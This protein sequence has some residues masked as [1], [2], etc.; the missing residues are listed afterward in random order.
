MG[1]INPQIAALL[2]AMQQQSAPPPQRL[3]DDPTA[4]SRGQTSLHPSGGRG[5]MFNDLVRSSAP[6]ESRAAESESPDHIRTDP[7]QSYEGASAQLD[8]N[9]PEFQ[10]LEG[11]RGVA[12][13]NLNAANP[14][15]NGFQGLTPGQLTQIPVGQEQR[16]MAGPPQETGA[17]S[18]SRLDNYEKMLSQTDPAK[19]A[20]LALK[21]QEMQMKQAQAEHKADLDRFNANTK[22][23]PIGGA[24]SA[25][26]DAAKQQTSGDNQ[27]AKASLSG[28]GSPQPT[29]PPDLLPGSPGF[30]GNE[31]Q[32]LPTTPP[33]SDDGLPS[34]PPPNLHS[35]ANTRNPG[36]GVAM[37]SPAS[38]M[39]D[40]LHMHK[41]AEAIASNTNFQHGKLYK[42]PHGRVH[43]MIGQSP[44]GQPL[45]SQPLA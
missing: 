34:T 18:E 39:M 19:A 1:Q 23:Y 15:T 42:S 5:R 13:D 43:Q 16:G 8:A 3:A 38:K 33:P 14:F 25:D 30:I 40:R 22:A 17:S 45:F 6:K 36:K 21:R 10:L 12:S 20:D 11:G 41:N 24:G 35:Q 2:G 27:K 37:L 7:Y 26:E 9:K 29:S 4:I 28:F 31:D 44:G 32:G